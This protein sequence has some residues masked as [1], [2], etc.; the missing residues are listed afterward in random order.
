M[1]PRRPRA[2]RVTGGRR[3]YLRPEVTCK[4]SRKGRRVISERCES[5]G[6]NVAV[7]SRRGTAG[8][9]KAIT[10]PLVRPCGVGNAVRHST[11]WDTLPS[12]VIGKLAK[13]KQVELRESGTGESAR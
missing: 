4:A 2:G 5:D 1:P 10:V 13:G 11:P 6:F 9:P 8:A 3:V 12:V 7:A